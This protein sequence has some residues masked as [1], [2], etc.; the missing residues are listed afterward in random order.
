MVALTGFTV[1]RIALKMTDPRHCF[2]DVSI[3]EYS[4]QADMS[5]I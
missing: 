5:Q 4:G 1:I 2:F 3:R